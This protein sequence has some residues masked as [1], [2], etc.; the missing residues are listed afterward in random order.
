MQFS[1]KR[2]RRPTQ[3]LNPRRSL[4][5][6]LALTF[7]FLVILLTIGLVVSLEVIVTDST[8]D[9]NRLINQL[10]RQIWV[11]GLIL[12]IAFFAIG[13]I[14]AGRIVRPLRLIAEAARE[15]QETGQDHVI[16]TFPGQDE[17]ASLSRSLNILVASLKTQQKALSEANDLLEQRVAERTRQLATLYDVLE[18]SSDKE[19][20]PT[21]LDRALTRI[22]QES[23]AD[24]GC[25]HLIEQDNPQLTMVSH[26]QMQEPIV[27]AYSHLCLDLPVVQD[28]LRQES[29][30]LITDSHAASYNPDLPRLTNQQQTLCLPIRRGGR[31]LGILTIIAQEKDSFE[32]EEIALLVS[33]A[34]QL[35]IMIEN[36]RL[37]QRAEQLVIVDERNRLARELHDSVTQALYSATLFAEAGQKQARSGNMDKALAFLGDVL[38]TSRQA[39]KEM[40][41]LVHK[42]RPSTLEKEGLIHALDHRLKAVEGRAGIEQKLIVNGRETFSAEI[43]D[44]L[45]HIAVEALN[46][47]LKHAQATAVTVTLDQTD[48][49]ITLKI[50]DNGQGFDMATAVSDGGLGLTSMQ[51]RVNLHD[52]SL[53][54][55]SMPGQGTTV[56]AVLPNN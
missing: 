42:L 21:L 29:Y 12:T 56:T 18:I 44:T 2:P 37:R 7:G 47:S 41:L 34:D 33:L 27:A 39:L 55:I 22:L 13:W 17:V 52:G 43:E 11:S 30:L 6:R 23:R 5:V 1:T 26:F 25:I 35:G 3:A 45:Y 31:D 49:A 48:T 38:D 9:P 40:R 15:Q 36:E 50:G 32:G 51:E 16:P 53:A 4:R 14:I 28:T 8:V 19:T 10:Q 24:V 20:L 54:I 46:N